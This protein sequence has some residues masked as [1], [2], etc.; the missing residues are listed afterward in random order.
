LI[1]LAVVG[2]DTVQCRRLQLGSNRARNRKVAALNACDL[3]RRQL[4]P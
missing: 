2:P 4:A 3:A 1:Y